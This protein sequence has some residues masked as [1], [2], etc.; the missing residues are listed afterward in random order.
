MPV[1]VAASNRSTAKKKSIIKNTHRENHP[2]RYLVR[3]GING[4]KQGFDLVNQPTGELNFRFM[5]TVT[6]V[7][8][9]FSASSYLSKNSIGTTESFPLKSSNLL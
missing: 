3:S 4:L 7:P 8:E 9:G 1:N 2:N 6:R 5:R